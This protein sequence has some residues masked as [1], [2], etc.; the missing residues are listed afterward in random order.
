MTTPLADTPE[1]LQKVIPHLEPHGRIAVDTEDGLFVPVLR[2][3]RTP[4]GNSRLTGK[5][6]WA[7][8]SMRTRPFSLAQTTSKSP[9]GVT[10]V[11]AALDL[12]LR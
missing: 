1:A 8:V 12:L 4:S 5:S 9:H 2:N 11:H 10:T 7:R 6:L 3:V